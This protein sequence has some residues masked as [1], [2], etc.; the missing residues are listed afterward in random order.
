MGRRVVGDWGERV[1]EHHQCGHSLYVN[2]FYTC[3]ILSYSCLISHADD[4][5]YMWF[6]LVQANFSGELLAFGSGEF[7]TV[8]DWLSIYYSW[9]NGYIGE[10]YFGTAL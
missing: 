2:G 1:N 10:H 3:I 4:R 7:F 6:K 9:E 8:Q 5:G